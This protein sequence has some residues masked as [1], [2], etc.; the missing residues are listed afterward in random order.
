MNE[1]LNSMLGILGT[2]LGVILSSALVYLIKKISDN[3]TLT[4]KTKGLAIKKELS[5]LAVTFIEQKF[6]GLTNEE[7]FKQASDW[8]SERLIEVGMEPSKKELEGL[9]EAAVKSFKKA[10]KDALKSV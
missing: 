9:I 4:S 1:L 6:E 2:T 7:K 8:L 10:N 5:L 3:Q